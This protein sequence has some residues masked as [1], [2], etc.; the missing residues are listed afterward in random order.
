MYAQSHNNDNVS[1]FDWGWDENLH[2][3]AYFILV[4]EPISQLIG[5]GGM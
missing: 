2:C 3:D 5:R 4:E 1:P